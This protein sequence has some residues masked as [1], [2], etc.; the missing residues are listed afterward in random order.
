MILVAITMKSWSG[1]T[2]AQVLSSPK[3]M[4]PM[5]RLSVAAENIGDASAQIK[6]TVDFV[7]K[8]VRGSIPTA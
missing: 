1:K 2:F 8:Q 6:E 5:V 4:W 3:G 7:K